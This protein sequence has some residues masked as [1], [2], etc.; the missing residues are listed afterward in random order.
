MTQI[1]D[2]LQEFP[3]E[4]RQTVRGLW[5]AVPPERQRELLELVPL[6]PGQPGKIRKIFQLAHQHVQMTLGDKQQVAI[7]G[8]A[9]VGK[10]TLYNQFVAA[11]SDRAEVGAVPGTTRNNQA[12][13][14]GPFVV[15]DTPGADAV[16]PVGVRERNLALEA[17]GLADFLVITFDAVQGIKQT[18]Q[19]LFQELRRLHK[20]YI[21]VLNKMDLVQ[22]EASAVITNAAINLGL[23]G[24][25]IIA[26]SA[27]EGTNL[28]QVVLAIV[29]AEPALLA[30]LGQGLPAYRWQLAWRVI[31]GAA[32][33][34]GLVALTPLPFVDFIPL[35][36]IQISMILGIAR[37]F[38]YRLTLGRM[39][40]VVS[41]LGLG[42]LARM[43]F[44]ELLKLGG[45]PA[46]VVAAA[47]AASTTI[48][49][50]YSASV[51]FERGERVTRQ[52][53]RQLYN[54][55]LE[56]LKEA[57]RSGGRRRFSRG[58]ISERI[59]VAMRG[60]ALAPGETTETDEPPPQA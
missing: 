19:Q 47:V 18:E 25:E 41:V 50:G 57:F 10:S 3:G 40:E 7:V 58:W 22:R 9:N 24:H 5:A 1:D 21:V 16:G 14:A 8:P 59:R 15:V 43:V 17:A 34:A 39:R 52:R 60:T 4:S 11:K 20:P 30:A 51:W 26:I 38:E 27:K 33:T 53:A 23:E 12:G 13:S 45:P 56:T 31:S 48:A 28:D 42:F 37:V 46:W 35:V 32:S 36:A 44:Y 6:L 55:L 49:M 54:A 2:L 29:K